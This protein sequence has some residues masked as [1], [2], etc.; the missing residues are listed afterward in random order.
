MQ[1][2]APSH[3]P[4]TRGDWADL[5]HGIVDDQTARG[6]AARIEKNLAL[7]GYRA[8][9]RQG[10]YVGLD[11]PS[12]PRARP[13]KIPL[14]RRE[15][16]LPLPEA[17]NTIACK[18]S[19]PAFTLRADARKMPRQGGRQAFREPLLGTR[20]TRRA[21]HVPLIGSETVA[22]VPLTGLSFGTHGGG[23]RSPPAENATGPGGLY[24]R[25]VF[26]YALTVRRVRQSSKP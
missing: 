11:K 10:G 26:G 4:H 1:N 5:Q 17:A 16:P 22:D 2:S 9:R 13:E 20:E 21:A 6:D 3:A 14:G 24:G 19:R 7:H 8:G 12:R 23:G 25:S 15:L 18:F